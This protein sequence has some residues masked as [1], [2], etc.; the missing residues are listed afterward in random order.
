MYVCYLKYQSKLSF[1]THHQVM[2]RK[3]TINEFMPIFMW[4]EIEGRTIS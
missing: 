2:V 1:I 3:L 4:I